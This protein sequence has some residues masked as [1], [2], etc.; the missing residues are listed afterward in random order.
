MDMKKRI[1]TLL[2]A[3][4][5]LA[6]NAQDIT[7]PV[8]ETFEGDNLNL[9]DITYEGGAVISVISNPYTTGINK[10]EKCLS[11]VTGAD[12]D[13]W[14]KVHIKPAEGVSIR[15]AS[16]KHVYFHFKGLRS[17]VGAASELWLLDPSNSES[18]KLAQIQFN[19][20][21][22]GVWEDFV[23]D[24]TDALAEG[25]SIYNIRIQPEL[26]FGTPVGETTY[27]FDDFQLLETSY[28]DGTDV[29]GISSIVDFDNEE[30]TAA[31][32]QAFNI[33]DG[34]GASYS[35]VEN[36]I[37]S[38]MNKTAKVIC[39][40]KPANATWWHALQFKINGLVKVEYPQTY[41]HVA[42]YAPDGSACRVI[43]KD[44]MGKQVRNEF[45][46][47]DASEWEDFVIDLS[48][49]GMN[50]ISAI[51]FLFGFNG[52]DNWANPAGSFYVDEIL[53][54]DEFSPREEINSSSAINP[55]VTKSKLISSVNNGTLYLSANG[56]S[57]AEVYAVNGVKVAAASVDNEVAFAL[58]AGIY[59][60]KA[61]VGNEAVTVRAIVK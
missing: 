11:V 42:Y 39:Y 16:D 5:V 45:T 1:F 29:K 24:I 40:N 20:T 54:N 28:P 48:E 3:A 30:L 49:G 9:T 22:A 37:S 43:V 26:N 41:L 46:P 6:V 58:P 50:S 38:V 27:L 13:W 34:E 53:L 2:A 36:P 8:I 7:T 47:Y 60:V 44:H 21:Q 31:N 32:I 17:R 25:K 52:E 19:N 56:L 33:T 23:V 14:H 15:A 10:S 55:V 59:I 57:K 61:I 51:E 18:T 4:A 12:H 35:I